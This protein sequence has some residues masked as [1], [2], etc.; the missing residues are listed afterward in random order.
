MSGDRIGLDVL[1]RALLEA[2]VAVCVAQEELCALDAAAGDGDLGTTLATGFQ[3]VRELLSESEQPD[4]GA[5]LVQVGLTLAQKAPSTI[6]T[7]L[8]SAFMRAG[9]ELAGRA[10]LSAA[11]LA[12]MLRAAATEITERG[13]AA[14]GERTVLDALE[15]AAVAAESAAGEGGGPT[16]G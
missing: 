13:Q 16:E 12:M 7:L 1:R 8:A 14:A 2:G 9:H 11:D 15:P 3:A 4:C 5:L 10:E 6:G